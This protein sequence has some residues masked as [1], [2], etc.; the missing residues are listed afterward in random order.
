MIM[1]A[2]SLRIKWRIVSGSPASTKRWVWL[3][4]MQ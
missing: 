3:E 2:S 4:V 1:V